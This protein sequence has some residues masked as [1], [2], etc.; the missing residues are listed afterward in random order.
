M[1]KKKNDF[2]KKITIKNRKAGFSYAFLEKYTAGIALKGTEVKSI[3]LGKA[4]LP[5][6]YCYF[7]KGELWIKGMYIA[8][9]TEGNIYNHLET[10]ERK[11]LLNKKELNKLMKGQDKGIT[12]VPIQ[13]FINERGFAKIQ[14]ALAKGK[15][16]YD[17]RATIKERDLNRSSQRDIMYS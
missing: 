12:I 4:S 3:R 5:E 13:L 6:S 8:H 10:R 17:K 15:K 14:I 1:T 7:F 2:S 16:E 9:Y 11:L